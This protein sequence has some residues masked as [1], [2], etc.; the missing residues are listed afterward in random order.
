M[1]KRKYPDVKPQHIP[2]EAYRK[3]DNLVLYHV[4]DEGDDRS[5]KVVV[6]VLRYTRRTK[7]IG[8]CWMHHYKDKSTGAHISFR[9]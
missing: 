7:R 3:R 6:N 9:V 4:T 2:R 5:S 1:Q 8:R